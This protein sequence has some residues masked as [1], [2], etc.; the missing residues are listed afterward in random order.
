MGRVDLQVGQS[1][2]NEETP[3]MMIFIFREVLKILL[4]AEVI[5]LLQLAITWYKIRHAGGQ[6]HYYS[7]TGTIKQ[8]DLNQ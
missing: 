1:L 3:K 2:T 7:R 8:R 6:A 4:L 5:G